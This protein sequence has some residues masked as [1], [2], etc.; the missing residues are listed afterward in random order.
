[1]T[2]QKG[3]IK[4]KNEKGLDIRKIMTRYGRS[5]KPI[6]FNGVIGLSHLSYYNKTKRKN[7]KEVDIR[8]RTTCLDK[9]LQLERKRT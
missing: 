9:S 5:L 6:I 2:K 1:M 8:K 7:E 3:Q 4:R